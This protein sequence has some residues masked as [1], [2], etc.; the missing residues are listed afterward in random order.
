[1]NRSTGDIRK[2]AEGP[3]P[4]FK[5]NEFIT[6]KL[7]GH[8]KGFLEEFWETIIYVKGERFDQCKFLLLEIPVDEVKTLDQ[9]ES[10]DEAAEKLDRSLEP[11][12]G[13]IMKIPPDVEFWGHCSNLQV[14][15]ENDYDS[16]LLH[17]NLAFPLL[18]KL[19]EAGD[20]LAGKVF[21]EEIAKRLEK[22][23]PTVIEY[24]I[25]EKYFNF[26]NQ[27]EIESLLEKSE[28]KLLENLVSLGYVVLKGVLFKRDKFR[29]RVNPGR[30]AKNIEEIKGLKFHTDLKELDLWSNQISE[31]TG[32]ETLINLE[33]LIIRGN[34]IREIKGLEPLA[35]LKELILSSNQITEIKG[36]ENTPNLE[37]LYLDKNQI[38]EIKGLESIPNLIILSL[39]G[40]QITEIKGLKTLKKLTH[41]DLG[42]TKLTDKSVS[43]AIEEFKALKALESLSLRDNDISAEVLEML[44]TELTARVL[45]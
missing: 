2:E 19:T 32:L 24:L 44:R 45:F 29:L 15:F 25:N 8:Y 4:E 18:K 3:R 12:H 37:V 43:D 13:P 1:L 42:R 7:E 6:L 5:V 26:L 20:P 9:I 36:V 38:S 33:T 40:N 23:S 31:I 22:S 35:N 17:R 39:R 10:I 16:R 27:E 34:Q 11:V 28:S 21:K 14:W 30:K 41:L